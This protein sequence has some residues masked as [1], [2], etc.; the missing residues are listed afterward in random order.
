LHRLASEATTS[1]DGGEA[2]LVADIAFA[3][4]LGGSC[5]RPNVRAKLPAEACAVSPGC[6]DAPCAA[7][8]AY[9]ACRSGSA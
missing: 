9:S 7:A 4:G 6:D 2:D 1:A 8:R 3:G 5:V